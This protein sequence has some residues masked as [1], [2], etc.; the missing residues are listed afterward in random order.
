MAFDLESK[1]FE[2]FGFSL[3]VRVKNKLFHHDRHSIMPL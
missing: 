3:Q 1:C 2:A